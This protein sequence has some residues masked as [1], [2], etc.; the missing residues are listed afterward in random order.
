MDIIMAARELGK[1]IQADERHARLQKATKA[2]DADKALQE[3][4]AKFNELRTDINIEVAKPDKDQDKLAK[5]DADFK[6]LYREI[7]SCP[8][9]IEFNEAKQDIDGIL[10]FVNQIIIGSINGENP[11]EIEENVACGGS[12]SSCSG[13]H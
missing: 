10:N 1:A 5:M 9:M 11:D 2:N 12:C 6:A 4:I 7:M 8:A 3:K 13:C